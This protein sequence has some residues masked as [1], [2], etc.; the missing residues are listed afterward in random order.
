MPSSS[1][2]AA[3]VQYGTL[4]TRTTAVCYELRM[5]K[6][7]PKG[8]RVNSIHPGLIATDMIKDFPMERMLRTVPMGRTAAPSEVAAMVAFLASSEA[9]YCNGQEFV[10][11]GGMHG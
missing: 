6:L 1:V 9:S 2:R 10:V 3:A 4:H 8:V 5:G 11:D 7:G